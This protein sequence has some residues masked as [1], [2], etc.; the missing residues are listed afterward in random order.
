MSYS[1]A[2]NDC[3]KVAS[4]EKS[5]L[6]RHYFQDHTRTAIILLAESL[7]IPNPRSEGRYALINEIIRKTVVLQ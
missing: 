4:T 2:V 6:I 1:C 5:H 7:G 3:T